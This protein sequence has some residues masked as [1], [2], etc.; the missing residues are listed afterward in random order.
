[1]SDTAFS[2][3]LQEKYTRICDLKSSGDKIE[4]TSLGVADTIP[5]FFNSESPQAI[6]KQA[7]ILM[8]LYTS[9]K[10][11]KRVINVMIP[12][13]YTYSQI[14]QM[15]SLK[16]K[17]LLSAI[18]Y[19]SD[20]FIPM[21]LDETELDIEILSED[22]ITKNFL[23]LIVAAPKKLVTRIERIIELAGLRAGNLE[24]ELSAVGRLYKEKLS[25]LYKDKTVLVVNFGFSSSSLY[26]INPQ[27]SFIILT[28]NFKIGLD[29]FRKD[30]DVNLNIDE[31]KSLEILKTVGF[32]KGGSYDTEV[33]LSPVLKEFAGEISKFTALA[34]SHFNLDINTILLC[35]YDNNISFFDKKI[36]ELTS[37]STTTLNLKEILVENPVTQSFANTLSSFSGVIGGSL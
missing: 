15:P 20:E 24:N 36:A 4:I 16:E 13:T 17:E 27:S 10:I 25:K 8:R 6:D 31:K 32:A 2:L 5:F 11:K 22:P 21:P 34:K 7:E 19:Q 26:L 33:I 29:L 12:D 9:L 18:R 23:V 28:R 14:I 30:L 35:N 37:L 1:M 3:D